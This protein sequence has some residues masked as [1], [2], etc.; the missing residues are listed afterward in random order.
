MKN[1]IFIGSLW[2]FFMAIGVSVQAQ[3]NHVT[4]K[5][6]EL[7]NPITVIISE[8]GESNTPKVLGEV[9]IE[10]GETTFEM[11]AVSFQTLNVITLKEGSGQLFLINESLPLTVN[12]II[13]E[14][15][16]IDIESSVEGGEG[17][18]QFS[19]YL[20]RRRAKLVEIATV[21]DDYSKE[22]L[23]NEKVQ[24][25]IM[26]KQSA[27]D[28]DYLDRNINA[29]KEHPDM[30]A[31]AYIFSDVMREQSVS[32]EDLKEIF[33]NFSEGLKGSYIGSQINNVINPPPVLKE[34]D[35][36]P[37]FSAPN[38]EGKEISLEEVLAMEGEY[39]LVEFWASWCPYCRREMPNLVE[40]Y[41][42][43]KDKGLKII[44]V[45]LDKK[46]SEW[47]DAID[48][49]GMDW[50]HVSHLRYWD[51]PVARLFN[52]KSVPTNYLLDKEGNIL[53][54]KMRGNQM[55]SKLKELMD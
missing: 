10:N 17:N 6:N 49:F 13:D 14:F 46:G 30:L 5:T 44:S 43:F 37:S 7:E 1:T 48:Q 16:G 8:I 22:D 36:A 33:A 3:T 31:S 29:M 21:T 47:T 2:L 41:E 28:R 45:S 27:I 51:E 34:G 40:T 12:L 18:K 35:A 26:D 53:A 52:V 50:I 11:D 24:R 9:E 32:D 39:T 38:P 19:E 15:G 20:Q 4:I 23:K 54:I 55:K 25:E 42:E